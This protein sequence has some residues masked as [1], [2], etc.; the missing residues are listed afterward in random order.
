MRF[1]LA[2]GSAFSSGSA[3]PNEKD[4]TD[5]EVSEGSDVESARFRDHDVIDK[6]RLGNNDTDAVAGD[7][8]E[9][10]KGGHEI[11]DDLNLIEDQ[12]VIHDELI[13]C[14]EESH[15]VIPT[16]AVSSDPDQSDN[17]ST[18]TS[19]HS[20]LEKMTYDPYQYYLEA[21]DSE[22][23][24]LEPAEKVRRAKIRKLIS[25]GDWDGIQ[26]KATSF[27]V[28]DED[29][30]SSP[31]GLELQPSPNDSRRSAKVDQELPSTDDSL[32]D[33]LDSAVHAG[34]W[35]AVAKIASDLNPESEVTP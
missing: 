23:E 35:A 32:F 7:V 11:V 14:S 9:L 29:S 22:N 3:L 34:D 31:V 5:Q 30:I 33:R 27:E 19:V 26:A 20:Q 24:H 2:L 12:D 16:V 1:L 8:M 21:E 13:Q 6:E 17:V 10:D 18:M 4:P 15:P 25:K 28:E